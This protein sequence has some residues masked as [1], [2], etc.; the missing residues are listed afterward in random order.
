MKV[1]TGTRGLMTEYTTPTKRMSM[2]LGS[3]NQERTN[4][5]EEDQQKPSI[6]NFFKLHSGGRARQ[7]EGS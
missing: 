3:C 4:L 1:M 5:E 2:C 7:E 6:S